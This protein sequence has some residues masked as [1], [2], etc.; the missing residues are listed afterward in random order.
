[1]RI[2]DREALGLDRN[3]FAI[4]SMGLEGI[5][6]DM[7]W[8]DKA[9]YLGWR[10]GCPAI[11]DLLETGGAEEMAKRY[12]ELIFFYQGVMKI[13]EDAGRDDIVLEISNPRIRRWGE[14]LLKEYHQNVPWWNR[15]IIPGTERACGYA[16][17]RLVTSYVYEDHEN[18]NQMDVGERL[19]LA[20]DIFDEAV[21]GLD[22]DGGANELVVKFA[23]RL[24]FMGNADFKLILRRVLSAG[25]LKNDGLHS[26]FGALAKVMEDRAPALWRVYKLIASEELAEAGIAEV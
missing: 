19:L 18:L 15:F 9:R 12:G 2:E 5:D 1:M 7:D 16:L 4:G 11:D 21:E 26:E 13:L 23:E 25:K 14:P 3:N 8:V 10:L 22:G 20:L 17:P 6:R 24:V